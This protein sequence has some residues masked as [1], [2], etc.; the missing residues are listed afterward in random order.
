MYLFYVHIVE[1]PSPD[2]M[3]DGRNEGRLISEAFRIARIPSSYSLAVAKN[4]FVEALTPGILK[5]V[6]FF[7]LY[8]ILHISAH[9]NK[10]GILLTDGTFLQW[11]ELREI[12]KPINTFLNNGLTIC[13]STCSGFSG[14]KMAKI[15][16][17]NMP[18]Y[19]I[20][21][22][23]QQL[24]WEDSAIA[25]MV[26]YNRLSKEGLVKRAIDAMNAASGGNNFDATLAAQVKDAFSYNLKRIEFQQFLEQL[27]NLSTNK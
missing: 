19:G 16:E 9:G 11:E 27:K 1:S 2:D 18:F 23:L 20:V 24:T 22:P 15:S 5:G 26:F 21:G 25:F 3:L 13:L 8:P 14:Y 12:L 17:E 7:K 10:N 6:D 4:K